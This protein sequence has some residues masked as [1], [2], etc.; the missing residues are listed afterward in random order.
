MDTPPRP[1]GAVSWPPSCRTSLLPPVR[2]MATEAAL[3]DHPLGSREGIHPSMNP[4]CAAQEGDAPEGLRVS[5]QL[6]EGDAQGHHSYHSHSPRCHFIL[7]LPPSITAL[8]SPE[9]LLSHFPSQHCLGSNL[10]SMSLS[11][12]ASGALSA[13]LPVCR[14]FLVL[15]SHLSPH[16]PLQALFLGLVSLF[17][18]LLFS[19]PTSA[20]FWWDMDKSLGEN[21]HRRCS[22]P[23]QDSPEHDK[24]QG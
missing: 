6:C 18:I 23:C 5:A 1:G 3:G 15:L 22:L 17:H 12:P 11:A 9:P 20:M 14:G 2:S 16:L 13:A 19:P 10:S 4:S 7:H 21:N 8:Q 24:G